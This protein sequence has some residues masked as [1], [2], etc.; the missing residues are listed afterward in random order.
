M[1]CIG[2]YK[3]KSINEDGE[4]EITFALDNFY[5]VKEAELLEKDV[6]YTLKIEKLKKKRSLQSNKF[7]WKLCSEIAKEMNG[8]VDEM[9]IYCLALENASTKFEYIGCIEDAAEALKQKFR[10]VRLIEKRENFNVYK[11][12]F[13]SSHFNQEEQNKIIEYVLDLAAKLNLN[14]TY[15]QELLK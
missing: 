8:D 5:S 11:V 6:K 15:W 3:R 2:T 14:T 12:Y 9:G 1:N 13:G 10:V 4:T 7:F